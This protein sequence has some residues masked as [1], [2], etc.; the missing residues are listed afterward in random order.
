[1]DGAR[2]VAGVGERLAPRLARRAPAPGSPLAVELELSAGPVSGGGR[3][4]L[5]PAAVEALRAATVPEEALL[6]ISVPASLRAGRAPLLP[7]E[8][9]ALAPADVVPCEADDRE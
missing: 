1:M 5:P 3:L 8:L 6:A 7:G 2:A 4:L 9:R